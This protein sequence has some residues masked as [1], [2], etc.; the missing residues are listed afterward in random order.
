MASASAVGDAPDSV[1]AIARARGS[2]A[3]GPI[4][5]GYAVVNHGTVWMATASLCGADLL[6]LGVAAD[7][8]ANLMTNAALDPVGKIREFKYCAV[9]IH[10][11]GELLHGAGYGTGTVA[12]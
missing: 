9:A 6:A 12:P 8:P 5:Y 7:A 11:D 3:S 2:S 4:A 10:R 1:G